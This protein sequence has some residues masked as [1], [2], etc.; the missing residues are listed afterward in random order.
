MKQFDSI[1]F[2]LDGTLVNLTNNKIIIDLSILDTIK[3]KYKLGIVTNATKKEIF[4]FLIN[5]GLVPKY[6]KIQSIITRDN[7]KFGKPDPQGI[8]LC[9]RKLNAKNL[10]FIGDSF[11]D[12]ITA[13]NANIPF[14]LIKTRRQLNQA[15]MK[16]VDEN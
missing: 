15:L 10:I 13:K 16:F 7:V 6:F 14:L 12:L 11:K 3:K 1:I 2:D 4:P 8:I 5:L 9:Q